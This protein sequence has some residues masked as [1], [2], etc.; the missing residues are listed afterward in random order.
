MFSFS[1]VLKQIWNN[2]PKYILI[3]N[4]PQLGYQ[5][6]SCEYKEASSCFM[7][8]GAWEVMHVHSPDAWEIPPWQH[9]Q[10][11]E[12]FAVQI[13]GAGCAGLGYDGWHNEDCVRALLNSSPAHCRV[14]SA[15]QNTPRR[16]TPLH[17]LQDI[18]SKEGVPSTDW[19]YFSTHRNMLQSQ[20]A[21]T[22]RQSNCEPV[23]HS[24]AQNDAD[25]VSWVLQGV[26][27]LIFW[28]TKY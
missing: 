12:S 19:P 15:W 26:T 24:G 6:F 18:N 14:A 4:S 8:P 20:N 1:L 5:H 23:E 28:P 11:K 3:L 25:M 13:I 17:T 21:I 7:C 22:S 9:L 16:T 10:P 27:T 2:C